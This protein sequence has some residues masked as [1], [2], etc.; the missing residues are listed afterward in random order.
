MASYQKISE[1][2][3]VLAVFE[4]SKYEQYIDNLT[5]T[6]EVM[7]RDYERNYYFDNYP[8]PDL[9]FGKILRQIKFLDLNIKSL[10]T[11]NSIRKNQ[12]LDIGFKATL[13]A[14]VL[15]L[16]EIQVLYKYMYDPEVISVDSS[17]S[18]FNKTVP[19]HFFLNAKNIFDD[20]MQESENI[21]DFKKFISEYYYYPVEE[22]IQT[23][24]AAEYYSSKKKSSKIMGTYSETSPGIKP[25]GNIT[26]YEEAVEDSF[27]ETRLVS[28][29]DFQR[30]KTTLQN[31]NINF[32]R[33]LNA[34]QETSTPD[35]NVVRKLRNAIENAENY[36]EIYDNILRVYD[37]EAIKGFFKEDA[38]NKIRSLGEL[39]LRTLATS[40][41]ST[42]SEPDIVQFYLNSVLLPSSGVG[43][44]PVGFYRNP[45]IPDLSEDFE[46]KWKATYNGKEI[47]GEE[48]V[49]ELETSEGYY[50]DYSSGG[51]YLGSLTRHSAAEDFAREAEEERYEEEAEVFDEIEIK[52]YLKRGDTGP[53]VRKLQQQLNEVYLSSLTI[54][55]V[56]GKN[57][58]DA[59][60]GF[61]RRYDLAE[62]GIVGN[63]TKAKLSE[64]ITARRYIEIQ[65]EDRKTRQEIQLAIPSSDGQSKIIND[66]KQTL[67]AVIREQPPE[68]DTKQLLK[69]LRYMQKPGSKIIESVLGTE[70]REFF[71]KNNI[72]EVKKVFSRPYIPS[73][74]PPF[75]SFGDITKVLIL[76]AKE[77]AKILIFQLVKALSI[78]LIDIMATKTRDLKKLSPIQELSALGL[79][80]ND[81]AASAAGS[82][83]STEP[84]NQIR[85]IFQTPDADSAVAASD[86]AF[87]LLKKYSVFKTPPGED[88]P[89]GTD[90]AEFFEE[91]AKI[92]APQEFIDLYGGVASPLTVDR[93]YAI[94]QKNEKLKVSIPSSEDAISMFTSL[95]S[96]IDKIALQQQEDLRILGEEEA[97]NS[98]DYCQPALE[99]LRANEE[100]VLALE[101]AGFSEDEIEEKM[102]EALDKELENIENSLKN[103]LNPGLGDTSDTSDDPDED[104]KKIQDPYGFEDPA[105]EEFV[106]DLFR[107]LRQSLNIMIMQDLI[108]GDPTRRRTRG[109]LDMVLSSVERKPGK[110]FS[111]I[112]IK[113]RDIEQSEYISSLKTKYYD[114]GDF[115]EEVSADSVK[116]KYESF[117]RDG[118]LRELFNLEYV[119]GQ[120]IRYDS[121]EEARTVIDKAPVPQEKKEYLNKISAGTQRTPKGYLQGWVSRNLIAMIIDSNPIS[122][123]NDAIIEDIQGRIR[124]IVS[125]SWDAMIETSL[126][127][128]TKKL[129]V[130]GSE[131]W[132]YGKGG[133][134]FQIIDA[135]DPESF[136]EGAWYLKGTPK[137]SGWRKIYQEVALDE[138]SPNSENSLFNV[139]SEFKKASMYNSKIPEDPRVKLPEEIF[140]KLEEKPYA[141]ANSKLN[142]SMLAALILSTI[143][144]YTIDGF[145]KGTPMFRVYALSDESY[146]DFF[147][148]YLT[149]TIIQQVL[150]EAYRTPIYQWK[151]LRA[152]GYYYI[153]IE[154]LVQT[155]I[156]MIN[157]DLIKPSEESKNAID[158]IKRQIVLQYVGQTEDLNNRQKRQKFKAFIDETLPF[159]RPLLK[160][161]V[162][163]ILDTLGEETRESY[164]PI[165][166]SLKTDMFE[167]WITGSVL[168]VPSSYETVADAQAIRLFEDTG[169]DGLAGAAENITLSVQDFVEQEAE[170]LQEIQDAEVKLAEIKSSSKYLEALEEVPSAE[171]GLRIAEVARDKAEE[172]FNNAGNII[173]KKRAE[174]DLV[175][176]EGA[177]S[178]AEQAL[179]KAE[180]KKAEQIQK[181]NEQ[182]RIINLANQA[183]KNLKARAMRPKP[184]P[185]VYQKYY[186]LFKDNGDYQ[187]ISAKYFDY[188][189]YYD[190]DNP[191]KISYG[192]RLCYYPGEQYI[193]LVEDT[194]YAPIFQNLFYKEKLRFMIPLISREYDVTQILLQDYLG[195]PGGNQGG[196]TFDATGGGGDTDGDPSNDQVNLLRG[197]V[198]DDTN[199]INFVL[200]GTEDTK[201]AQDALYDNCL[202]LPDILSSIT[203]YNIE[204][205]IGS[206]RDQRGYKRKTGEFNWNGETFETTKDLLKLMTE[207]A[208][209][210]R[211]PKYAR[212]IALSLPRFS[213]SG[214][215]LAS[216]LQSEGDV[217][218]QNPEVDN[219]EEE[220]AF[221][222][223]LPRWKRK[224]QIPPLEDMSLLQ[225]E[226]DSADEQNPEVD[227][228]EEEKE[229]VFIERL[230]SG[231]EQIPS[232][233]DI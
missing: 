139:N 163:S 200:F 19:I 173:D 29:Q 87:E 179:K 33:V 115:I 7:G 84:L 176:A 169:G 22:N 191:P 81:L 64:F 213:F 117:D 41:M 54:D 13:Q 95:G 162:S 30:F 126:E 180:G 177:V 57:T 138:E 42:A 153:F 197:I 94:I 44:L 155:Y 167:S 211:T 208:Y 217:D 183:I 2:S 46:K 129:S 221:V 52:S 86:E 5:T 215:N 154:Q 122:S 16:V 214:F 59:V 181:V 112:K 158:E 134:D 216:L 120:E 103:A 210:A 178:K 10:L 201:L 142:N 149:E 123:L 206:V 229:E 63:E 67:I 145:L 164:Q 89:S 166:D 92:M 55:G 66:I 78:K 39:P 76:L 198:T 27:K 35:S 12:I 32:R 170:K 188:A 224:R 121:I 23:T 133:R 31:Q 230:Y 49:P 79:A 205:F 110:P 24:S 82:N 131:A 156:N 4:Y 106:E 202:L 161:L 107:D 1:G 26:S 99:D 128:F 72:H 53:E 185:F 9:K 194:E 69:S 21:K 75:P 137:S 60:K 38:V 96:L 119:Y 62:D 130:V 20:T 212:E 102:Q 58:F 165:Y 219:D 111:K 28:D 186:K 34:L 196:A 172:D 98:A 144:M 48:V 228:S 168:D 71:E 105:V 108:I 147:K 3:S 220:E 93:V 124:Q 77:A 218:E 109:F 140:E 90:L 226:E 182:Q 114:T 65:E 223:T 143:K 83:P 146:G 40:I 184:L 45:E 116:L 36:Q 148:S 100:L 73:Q 70:P 199:L 195:T 50:V 88:P 127:N 101:K 160:D 189:N 152:K 113:N 37:L 192:I 14:G 233:E 91:S 157:T 187:I 118:D 8:V 171:E 175:L 136:G 125:N 104:E 25:A 80:A 159:A 204:N 227:N 222:K 203:I 132:S 231:E 43:A 51:V 15:K 209:Y 225:S 190:A 68:F 47:P 193:S 151:K 61:Q 207:Q 17:R 74:L 141:R 97:L 85:Q 150:V 56:F 11:S 232:L 18:P 6:V 135:N 174:I